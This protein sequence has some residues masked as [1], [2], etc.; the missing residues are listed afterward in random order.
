MF[1]AIVFNTDNKGNKYGAAG[2]YGPF[3]HASDIHPWC[4]RNLTADQKYEITRAHN[5][6]RF[7]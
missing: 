6:E 7:R 2:L 4:S 3:P 1:Y 5:P